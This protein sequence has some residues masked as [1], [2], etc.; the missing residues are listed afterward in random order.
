MSPLPPLRTMACLCLLAP[1][2]APALASQPAA[3]DAPSATAQTT[4]DTAA[5]ATGATDTPPATLTGEWGGLRTR[6]RQNGVDLF[7]GYTS[8]AAGNLTGGTRRMTTETAQLA[9]GTTIDTQKLL[10]LAGGTFQA[11]V[12]FRRGDN[13]V[14]NAGLGT[15]QQP[16]EIYGYGQTTRLTEF[17]YDQKLGGGVDVKL[18][19][20]PVGGDFNSFSC[21]TMSNYFCGAPTGNMFGASWYNWPASQW[22]GRVKLNRADWYVQLGAYEQNPRNLDNA[23]ILGLFHGATGVLLPGEVGLRAHLGAGH[24]PGLYRAGGWYNTANADDVLLNAQGLPAVLATGTMLRRSGRYGGFLM[25]QQ[26]LTGHFTQAPG[27]EATMTQGLSIYATTTWADR[28][29]ASVD[30]QV[31]MG[32]R[33]LGLPGR[34]KDAITINVGRDHVNT[35]LAQLYALRTA[36]ARYG[37]ETNVELDYGLQLTGWLN[38]QPNVQFI[39]NPGGNLDRARVTVI[40]IKTALTL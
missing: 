18:G 21:D 8:E 3:P 7:A 38:L 34:P 28:Y 13:L 26:Q 35:R 24:L 29:S 1:W 36:G 15:L 40:G 32:L 39:S 14:A 10:G 19:R 4:P 31:T 37:A 23:F 12:T 5:E 25:A 16:Q 6:L 20:L 2:A 22:A 27:A 11:T 33:W 9:F 17:W 30:N